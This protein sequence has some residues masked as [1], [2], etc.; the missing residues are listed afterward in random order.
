MPNRGER[1]RALLVGVGGAAL[2]WILWLAGAAAFST[3][4]FDRLDGSTLE[5]SFTAR[6]T[7]W[8]G[9]AAATVDRWGGKLVVLVVD[10]ETLHQPEFGAWPLP[11]KRYAELIDRLGKAG[12]RAVGL[13]IIFDVPQ[14]QHAGSDEALAAALQ[15]HRNVVLVDHLAPDARGHIVFQEPYAALTRGWTDDERRQRIGVTLLQGDQATNV[16][17]VPVV[18]ELGDER[19][20]TFDTLLAARLAGIPLESVRGPLRGIGSDYM[21][22]GDRQVPLHNGQML[23]NYFWGGSGANTAASVESGTAQLQA[24]Q[25]LNYLP[26]YAPFQMDG[27]ELAYYFK[28]KVVLVGVTAAGGNDLKSTPMGPMSGIDIHANVILDLVSGQ[29]LAVLPELAQMLLV[30]A[31]GLL[32]GFAVP[33]LTTVLAGL[34]VV[35]LGVLVYQFLPPAL[36]MRNIVFGPSRPILALTFAFVAA[37]AYQL[38]VERRTRRRLA[39]VVQR[40]IERAAAA[41]A[42]AARAAATPA[43][44]LEEG[45]MLAHYRV[46]KK[47]GEGGMGAVYRAHD[48]RLDRTVA[49][50]VI[51][52]GRGG[53]DGPVDRF[54]VEA[55]SVAGIHH[56]SIVAVYD[57]GDDPVHY[58]AMQYVEGKTLDAH[59]GGQALEPRRAAELAHKIALA[60]AV[61]H[62]NAIVHRDLKPQNLMIDAVGEIHLMDFGLARMLD[63]DLSLT[64]AGEL[65]GTPRYM[66]PEQIDPELGATDAQSDLWALGVILYEMLTG[67][68]PFN[69]PSLEVLI[70]ELLLKE[71]QRPSRTNPAIPSE[72]DAIA[73]K[74]LSKMKDERY[75]TADEVA[76]D[77]R[78]AL[79]GLTA[80]AA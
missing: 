15:R 8:A 47:L 20:L 22:F 18:V 53:K 24:Q 43:F 46:E 26:F 74:L 71:P 10:D 56:P 27:K 13:D 72:L 44:Q 9:E 67:K 69:A 78:R 21:A 23:V 66:A 54:M 68:P 39:G 76:D 79:H 28:D 7:R 11:R 61:I 30:I 52:R 19:R 65:L 59:L 35:L 2:A 33:R 42:A 41:E 45:G 55:R 6:S 31:L 73:E 3:S 51:L 48:T 60:L 70:G 38:R 17:K 4:L 16:E 34:L 80:A 40:L 63:T 58:L 57:V 29:F 12:A 14:S 75:V 36:M 37:N 64:R 50:K 62:Q 49:L 32:V 25:R 77:L 5:H 1:L